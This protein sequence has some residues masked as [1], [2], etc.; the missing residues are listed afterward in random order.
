MSAWL[1]FRRQALWFALLSLGAFALSQQSVVLL[2]LVEVIGG[3]SWLVAR[4]SLAPIPS[5]SRESPLRLATTSVIGLIIVA[6]VWG[7]AK[8]D[9]TL[10]PA[11]I[12][13]AI[14]LL[15]LFRLFVRRTLSGERQLL[16]LS[17]VL[18]IVAV[19]EANDL[20][21]AAFVFVATMLGVSCVIQYRLAAV[22][23]APRTNGALGR[24]WFGGGL[25]PVGA[26]PSADLKRTI[27]IALGLIF[28]ITLTLF[29]LFP[30]NP[31]PTGG[32]FALRSG[33]SSEFPDHI[34]LMSPQRLEPSQ[35]EMLSVQWLGPDGDPLAAPGILRLR[36]VI[37]ELY[38]TP[39]STWSTRAALR[40]R[41]VISES[42]EFQT[43]ASRPV[44]E[45]FNTFTQ[46]V[47]IRGLRSDVILSAW[48]PV[49][50]HGDT[51]QVYTID[52]RTLSLRTMD[53]D[54]AGPIVGYDLRV[55]PFASDSV[56]AGLYRG[57]PRIPPLATFPVEA[58]R[59]EAERILTASGLEDLAQP[60]ESESSGEDLSARWARNLRIARAF[61]N[62]LTSDRFRYTLDLRDFV[63]RGE[64]DPIDLFLTE[65]RFGHCEYFASALCA[66]CQSVGVDA[67]VVTGFLARDY[68]PAAARYIVRESDAHAWVEIR[69]GRFQWTAVDA[70]PADDT[71]QT[72]SDDESWAS[73]LRILY[74]PFERV[75]QS[76]VAQFDARAQ[77]ALMQ[78]S[79]ERVGAVLRDAWTALELIAV[80]TG[81]SARI[82]L[83]GYI[84]FGS[85]LVTVVF[86]VAAALIAR[87][88]RLRARRAL[89]VTRSDRAAIR[90]AGFYV[91][92]LD[93]LTSHGIRRPSNASPRA[94]AADVQQT[95]REAG[96]IFSQIVERFY[97]IRFGSH[98]PDAHTRA[99]DSARVVQLKR[100]LS[101]DRAGA[102]L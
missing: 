91:E 68:Q 18:L 87:R 35:R 102:R 31:N 64:R 72:P 1:S 78:R 73:F 70:T 84:W 21:V 38:D 58:V 25:V 60:P 12:G 52:P 88:K 24:G 53:I 79:S 8:D 15:L 82:G 99:D 95:H 26:T 9:S 67:R 32:L 48:A 20:L 85:V 5:E 6:G 100:A 56:L 86:S 65:Y 93:L 76:Q 63:R 50:I 90:D 66:L 11:A 92:A 4:A 33:H 2:V 75:W 96:E 49:A 7:Y 13:F 61:E 97:A 22:A 54:S 62:E 57:E 80:R 69:T 98:H 37:L 36:G 74:E 77:T 17:S 101:K 14:C 81:E 29:V 23:F 71:A 59:I 39:T 30:R 16:M 42:D 44:D 43:L 34:S 28:A 19:L 27:R 46:R 10:L 41:F 83:A 55:Q 51:A 47:L 94:F 40:Q 89:G 45:R 3:A